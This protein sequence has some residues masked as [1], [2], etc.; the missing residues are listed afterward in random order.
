MYV[1]DELEP[2][3]CM[4]SCYDIIMTATMNY[5]LRLPFL[6]LMR[7]TKAMQERDVYP[8]WLYVLASWFLAF[9][10]IGSS[11]SWISC[12][13]LI[14]KVECTWGSKLKWL[15][16]HPAARTVLVGVGP[17]PPPPLSRWCHY[18]QVRRL[19]MDRE[20]AHL[21]ACFT[22]SL[23][24]VGPPWSSCLWPWP[25][26]ATLCSVCRPGRRKHQL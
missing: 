6:C 12:T 19:A 3:G 22:C 15:L 17:S 5:P 26:L 14:C 2:S 7:K 21:T 1:D 24:I 20:H 25:V 16:W 13:P 23:G 4:L 18:S 10:L 9:P 11:L 8:I